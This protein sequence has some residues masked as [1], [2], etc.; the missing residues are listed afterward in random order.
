MIIRKGV[1]VSVN[2]QG[3]RTKV[4]MTVILG[5][6]FSNHVLE[7]MAKVWSSWMCR[8]G[9][10]MLSMSASVL[11]ELDGYFVCKARRTR[12]CIE[13]REMA[14]RAHQTPWNLH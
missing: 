5:V 9:T 14:G 10:E 12:Y 2:G 3:A 6:F 7:R 4:V 13:H 1:H 11:G 8:F